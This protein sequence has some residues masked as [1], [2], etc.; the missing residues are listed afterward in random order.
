M[1]GGFGRNQTA[2]PLPCH[3]ALVLGQQRT[4]SQGIDGSATHGVTVVQ[5]H[6]GWTSPSSVCTILVG[7][8][9]RDIRSRTLHQRLGRRDSTKPAIDPSSQMSAAACICPCASQARFH[10]KRGGAG[11]GVQEQVVPRGAP[12]FICPVSTQRTNPF[13]M[14]QN[15]VVR[16]PLVTRAGDTSISGLDTKHVR[17]KAR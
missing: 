12:L 1:L 9:R 7:R 11:G 6:V 14:T 2:H 8:W 15:L 10:E 17:R 4:R 16:M 13:C 5:S 3:L